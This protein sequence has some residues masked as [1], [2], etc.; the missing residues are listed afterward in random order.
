MIMIITI[1]GKTYEKLTT[2]E[3]VLKKNYQKE[4][5]NLIDKY[6]IENV[7]F[8]KELLFAY[9][10][11]CDTYKRWYGW[12]QCNYCSKSDYCDHLQKDIEDDNDG[13]DEYLNNCDEYDDE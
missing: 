13:R 5:Q 8:I 2:R 1:S 6:G 3:T 11:D 9:H 7:H 10:Y 4:Y 12:N